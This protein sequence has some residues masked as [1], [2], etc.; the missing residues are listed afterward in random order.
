VQSLQEPSEAIRQ[1]NLGSPNRDHHAAMS[2]VPDLIA[3][4]HALA[5]DLSH[6]ERIVGGGYLSSGL[7][8]STSPYCKD[9]QHV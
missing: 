2:N 1:V 6:E 4:V 5:L 8:T 3:T 9:Q 7:Y